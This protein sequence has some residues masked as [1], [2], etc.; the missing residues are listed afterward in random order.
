MTTNV[1]DSQDDFNVAVRKAVK[2]TEKENL[3]KN[4]TWIYVYMVLWV[5]FFVWAVLL[6]MKIETGPTKIIH[7]VFAMLCSPVYVVS[8]YLGMQETQ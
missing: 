5:V 4:R 3:K 1:C 7:L 6:A 2:F 8:Y